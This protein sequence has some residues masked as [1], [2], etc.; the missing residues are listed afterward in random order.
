[1]E[2][3]VA[4]EFVHENV[5]DADQAEALDELLYVKEGIVCCESR[6]GGVHGGNK[7][8]GKSGS[9]RAVHVREDGIEDILVRLDTEGAKHDKEWNG[10]RDLREFYFHDGWIKFIFTILKTELIPFTFPVEIDTG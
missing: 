1:M 7:K 8:L 4:E 10:F 5:I 3:N 6:L 9:L 2:V